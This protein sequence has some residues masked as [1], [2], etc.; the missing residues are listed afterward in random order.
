MVKWCG[1]GVGGE[2]GAQGRV[3][4]VSSA[5]AARR[6]DCSCLSLALAREED[7][8]STMRALLLLASLCSAHAF[9]QDA[10]TPPS[11][12]T[13]A[14]ED[15]GTAPPVAVE[16]PPPAPRAVEA[17][18]PAEPSWAQR[19]FSPTGPLGVALHGEVGFLGVLSHTIQFGRGGTK[20]DYLSDGAQNTLFPF[21]RLSADVK[22]FRRNT[23]VLL[24][25]P[26]DLATSQLASRD[27]VVD[28]ETFAAGT[29][30]DFFYGFSF[31]RLSYLYNFFWKQPGM[32]LAVGLSLQIRNARITFASRDGTQFRSNEDIGPVPILK[33]RARYTFQ[34]KVWLGAEVDGFYAGTPGFNGSD[35][36]FIGSILDASLRAGVEVTPAIDAFLNVRTVMGGAVGT[37]RR[38]RPPADGYVENWLYTFTASVGFSL[39]V[40]ERD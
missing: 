28:G 40:P 36:Q 34:N 30:V 9:A 3:T 8:T 21:L 33:L 15:A 35:N 25:Q 13:T 5:H 19:L 32:E 24:Y 7:Q 31:W 12:E 6:S 27:L 26:L 38:P 2:R 39:K 37:E 10:V 17:P 4:P 18:A 20:I 1:E 14:A 16:V 23:I 11:P 29:P 22:L